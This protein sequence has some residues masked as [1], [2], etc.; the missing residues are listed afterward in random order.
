MENRWTDC[1]RPSS[2]RTAPTISPLRR[3]ITTALPLELT[4]MLILREYFYTP[5]RK[6]AR[7]LYFTVQPAP[8]GTQPDAAFFLLPN[9]TFTLTYFA[10]YSDTVQAI[11][12]SRKGL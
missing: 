7:S 6:H 8:S 1:Y 5:I 12:R 4:V 11:R 2:I 10:P 3:T 9:P